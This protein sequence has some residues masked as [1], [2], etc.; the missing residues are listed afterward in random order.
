MV[1][2]ILAYF[3]LNERLTLRQLA[4]MCCAF[5]SVSLVIL[6]GTDDTDALYEANLFALVML[7][8]NPLAF[9]FG[10]IAMKKMQNTSEWTV[11]CY[12]NLTMFALFTPFVL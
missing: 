3:I 7:L 8:L 10:I 9:G 6:G 1:V 12:V 2:V 11:T 4:I 5:M